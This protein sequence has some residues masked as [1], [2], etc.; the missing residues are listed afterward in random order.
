MYFQVSINIKTIGF[1]PRSKSKLR[2]LFPKTRFN[3]N[4]SFIITMFDFQVQS[5]KIPIIP[6]IPIMFLAIYFT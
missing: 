3:Q 5:K 6:I 4:G 2:N 1:S